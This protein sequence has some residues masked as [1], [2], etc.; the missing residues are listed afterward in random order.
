MYFIKMPV[1]IKKNGV[2]IPIGTHQGKTI[3]VAADHRGFS[4]KKQII[5]SLRHLGCQVVDLGAYSNERCDY[6]EISNNLGASV[7]KNYLTSAGIGICGSGIGIIQCAAKY[8]RVIA[9]RC[10]TYRDA[11]ISRLHNNSNVLGL[12]SDCIDL[13]AAIS[14]ISKWITTPFY[15]G[16]QDERYLERCAQAFLLEEKMRKSR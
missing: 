11:E 8:S 5:E 12:G 3:F 15:R 6:P 16:I 14:I 7:S 2:E 4:Y 10:L 1:T 9:A 13:E